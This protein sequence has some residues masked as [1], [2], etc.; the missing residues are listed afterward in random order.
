MCPTSHALVLPWSQ[1]RGLYQPGP[2]KYGVGLPSS[3]IR[4]VW[5]SVWLFRAFEERAFWNIDSRAVRMAVAVNRAIDDEAANGVL[6]TQNLLDP[7]VPGYYVNVQLGEIEVANPAG[8]AVPEIFAIVPG[9][10]G[11]TE[12]VRERFSSLSPDAPLLSDAEIE[13][14]YAAA[15]RVQTHF[16]ELYERSP[17]NLALDIEFKFYGPERRLLIKQVRPYSVSAW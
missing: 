2:R 4:D 16:A 13:A 8:G 12:I 17:A 1:G 14:L 10:P 3:R 5:A 7:N 9:L 6:I 15:E 11:T